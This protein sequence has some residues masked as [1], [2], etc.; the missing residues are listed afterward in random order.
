MKVVSATIDAE[1]PYVHGTLQ[2][3]TGRGSRMG[4]HRRPG[5]AFQAERA[6]QAKVQ[7][8]KIQNVVGEHQR[9]CALAGTQGV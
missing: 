4:Q 1:C 6:A 8:W 3:D 9:V 7:G 2:V 5:K